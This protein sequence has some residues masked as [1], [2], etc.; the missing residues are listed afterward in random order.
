MTFCLNCDLANFTHKYKTLP[1]E[2][3]ILRKG[4][5]NNFGCIEVKSESKGNSGKDFVMFI[6]SNHGNP[7]NHVLIQAAIVIL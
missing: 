5:T 4:S 6:I 7:C 3:G 1:I 2:P